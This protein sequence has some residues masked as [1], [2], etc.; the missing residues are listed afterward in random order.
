MNAPYDGDRGQGAADSGYPDDGQPP[1]RAVA[2]RVVRPERRPERGDQD[3]DHE[4]PDRD[5]RDREPGGGG[6]RRIHRFTIR[7]PV[8]RG[9]VAAGP[10]RRGSAQP[11]LPGEEHR[12]V[13]GRLVEIE[14]E[15]SPSLP[16]GVIGG[17]GDQGCRRD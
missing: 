2:G 5:E 6:A 11:E 10:W 3:R 8:A 12:S 15:E 14:I 1:G 17:A 13:P 7:G 16:I 4:Q 9:C